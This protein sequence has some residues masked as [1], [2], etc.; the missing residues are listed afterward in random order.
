MLSF[1]LSILLTFQGPSQLMKGTD[2][3][4]SPE[5]YVPADS[6]KGR[7]VY[8]DNIF[9]IGNKVTKPG[10]ILRELSVMKGEYYY[11][12]DLKDILSTDRKKILNTRLF[13]TVEVTP[14]ELAE[15]A[16]D[17][18]IRVTERWYTFP[19]PIF[20]LVDRNFNDWWENQD[21]DLSRVNYGL[22]LYRNNMRGRNETLRLQFQLGYT[23]QFDIAYRIPY[24][25][26]SQ[27]HGISI[28]YLYA[29]NK[30]IAFETVEHKRNFLDSEN[31]LRLQRTYLLGYQFRNSFY[32]THGVALQFH[33]NEIGDTVALANPEYFLD[34]QTKQRFFSLYYDLDFDRR[35]F[36]S[37][38]LRGH[39]T[40]FSFRKYG[41]GIFNDINQF[42][43][44]VNH[45]RYFDLKRN[46]FL[47]NYSSV[48]FSGPGEQPYANRQGLGYRKDFIRGYELYVIEG[49]HF[50]LNRTTLKKRIFDTK[51]RVGLIPIEQFK[52]VPLAIYI[53][54]YFDMGYTQNFEN[55]TENIRLAD[56]YLFG[57]GA[58][59][60]IVS[61]YDTVFRLE[62]SINREQ[63]HGFFVHLKK[64]F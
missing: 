40:N 63:E 2:A 34:G 5:N 46:F 26:R 35:D 29:E 15:N 11:E 22:R 49:R 31:L 51:M 33:D 24:I 16:V 45:S 38:P 9:I 59:I 56:R 13:N 48:Y 42:D 18:I 58:G 41:V 14:L 6:L 53:K 47:A 28:G 43:I 39:K 54:T 62:Y 10:I 32:T 52:N 20:D 17:I 25:D 3:Q 64:E 57:T 55:Y 50:Y 7:Y 23:K 30:N 1:L 44:A 36:N 4:D 12:E 19:A 61:Y 27:R 21:R 8:I 37:Y 60:D